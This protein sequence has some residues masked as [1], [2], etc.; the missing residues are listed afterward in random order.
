MEK[1]TLDRLQECPL[2]QDIEF[3]GCRKFLVRYNKLVGL[4]RLT[5]RNFTNPVIPVWNYPDNVYW[6][7][8]GEHPKF[9]LYDGNEYLIE[10]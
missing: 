6:Y 7:M 3:M 8:K 9:C 1:M 10:E 2:I 4:H 5:R